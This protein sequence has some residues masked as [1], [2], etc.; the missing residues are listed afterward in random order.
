[1][2]AVK[3]RGC[4]GHNPDT[5]AWC[6]QCYAPLHQE[7]ATVPP[8]PPAGS[9][10]E[11]PAPSPVPTPTRRQHEQVATGGRFRRVGDEL[12][13]RCNAC[14]SWSL[15]GATHCRVC[16]TPFGHTASGGEREVPGVRDADPAG[17]AVASALLPGAGHV[18]LGRGVSGVVRATTYLAWIAGGYVVTRAAS[19]AGQS[20]LPAV[21]L[22]LGALAILVTSVH[23]AYVLARRGDDELLTPRVLFWI[24]VAVI[25]TLVL[26]FIPTAL[27]VGAG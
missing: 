4:G 1:M 10:L 18:L 9:P 25:G 26:S 24:V 20:I 7:P 27:R 19:A 12:E 21:P 5:A 16:A 14:A 23:D 17:M 22:L 3:C 13:W 6:S 15:V 2:E 11:A 8:R